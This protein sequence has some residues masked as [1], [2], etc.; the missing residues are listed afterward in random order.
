[1]TRYKA[2]LIHLGISTV[3]FAVLAGLIV[4]V[5][6]PPPF[7]ANDGG[8]QGIRIVV[9]V[10][11]VLGPGLTLLVFKPG[12]PGLKF[13][14]SMIALAQTAALIWGVWA[15]YDQRPVLVTFADDTFYTMTRGQVA[16]AGG[17]AP[18]VLAQATTLPAFAYVRLPANAQ[19]RIALSLAKMRAGVPMYMIGE[20]FEPMDASNLDGVL[21]ASLDVQQ[22]A[23][24]N[25]E[26]QA[27]LQKL[28]EREQTDAESL[29]Y[30]LLD[31]RYGA[32][33]LVLRR[34]DGRVVDTLPY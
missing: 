8:W 6:Y 22:R 3:I 4:F 18:Q 16:E 12:K 23:H 9:L 14:L 7:F 1:M 5:W 19:E 2:Y 17:Q 21:A 27:A 15:I 29:A 30:L 34:E 11:M 20:H 28:L 10:D 24:K 13:D 25:P 33:I 26:L 31:G 32:S